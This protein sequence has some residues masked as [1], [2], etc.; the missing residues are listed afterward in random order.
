MAL[1]LFCQ[2]C[3]ENTQIAVCSSFCGATLGSTDRLAMLQGL[4]EQLAVAC[5]YSGQLPADS[6]ALCNLLPRL[7]S[8]GWFHIGY[9]NASIH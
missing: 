4:C 7:V 9:S 1:A 8:E 3:R 6:E 2:R 5:E